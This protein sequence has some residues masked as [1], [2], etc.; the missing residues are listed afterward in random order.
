VLLFELLSG[1]PPYLGASATHVLAAHLLSPVP[2]LPA[3]GPH[4]PI[5]APLADLVAQMMAKNAAERPATMADVEA[6]LDAVLAGH[7]LPPS[8]RRPPPRTRTR[9]ALAALG[10][11][12]LVAIVA[13]AFRGG[14]APPPAAPA[15]A[16][17]SSTPVVVAPPA[18]VPSSAPA[19]P[20]SPAP[21]TEARAPGPPAAPVA[22]IER[23]APVAVELR[24]TPPG[25]RVTLHG[26]S[27]GRTPLSV[28]LPPDRAVL[29]VFE[30]KGRLSIAERVRAHDGLVV[31]A[32]LPP[33]AVAPGLD[34]LKSSPY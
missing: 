33:A 6:A 18:P 29:L 15:P 5:P 32:H 3:Q 13:L 4:G 30:A 1:A 25:A 21:A 22:R 27:L 23:P 20:V 19:A 24:S 11:V 16:S 31:T 17:S 34:D 9:Q 28:R 26:R 12:A 8:L 10:A 2:R 14:R 7:E